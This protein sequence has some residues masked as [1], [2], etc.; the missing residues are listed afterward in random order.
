MITFSFNHLM[1]TALLILINGGCANLD[2][3]SNITSIPA[4]DG[5]ERIVLE[6]GM[7]IDVYTPEGYSSQNSYPLLILNDGEHMFGVTGWNVQKLVQDMIDENTI[8]PIIVAA[9]H[10]NG[11]RNNWYV[12]YEDAWIS[13]NWGA[14]SPQAEFYA[15]AVINGV[16]PE[17]SKAYSVEQSEIGIMGASLGGLIST[18][19]GIHY[20]ETIK[21]S[22]GLSGSLWVG[23]YEIFEE[24]N[25]GYGSENKFWFDIGTSEWNYYVPLYR[26]LVDSGLI[27]GEQSFYY[28]VPDGRHT[29]RDWLNRIDM[30]LKTFFGTEE[31]AEPES[32]ETILECIPSQS[33]PGRKFRR[34]NPVI[35][36]SNGVKFSLAQNATYELK[37]GETQLGSEG[38][39]LNNPDLESE[40]VITYKQFS[41]TVTIPVN[42]CR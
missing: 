41:D 20:P 31:E 36:M 3:T 37:S 27:A 5:I 6:N 23:D 7:T 21:Y 30:P 4:P 13:Q 16:I 38:S 40:I 11:K 42:W 28:E 26:A 2:D 24:V 17:I 32:M 1:I 34:M 15:N 10:S 39:L 19:M 29:D 33:T 12:P 18:W 22:A 9:I 8:V 25:Q 35:T 14:Y